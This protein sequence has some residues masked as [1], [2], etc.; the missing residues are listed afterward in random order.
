VPAKSEIH[1]HRRDVATDTWVDTGVLVD[2]RGKSRQDVLV[3]GPTVYMVSRFGFTGSPPQNRLLRFTYQP[4]AQTY[5]PDAG[6]PVDIAGGGAEALTVAKD[7]RGKLWIAYALNGQVQVAHTL[8]SDA[9]WTAPFQPPVTEGTIATIDDDAGVIAL[10]GGKIGVFWSNQAT[11]KFY[12]GIH[13]DGAPDLDRTAWKLETAAAGSLIADDHFNL[14]LA[15]DGR[16]FVAVKTSIDAAGQVTIGLLVR[17][18]AGVWSRLYAVA[19]FD[20]RPSRPICVLD[21]VNRRVYVLYSSALSDIY[22]KVSDMNAIAFPTTDRG[23]PFMLSGT[24]PNQGLNDPTSAKLGPDPTSG[25][26]ILA[27]TSETNRY[28][29]NWISRPTP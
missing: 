7:S 15:A 6:F 9:E 13:T 27:S 8:G 10:P 19:N 4:A 5:T 18:A 17:S 1:I 2:D 16:L 24:S 21:E 23:T 29:H 14:K 28:W 3:D 11:Q 22:Y 25:I 12:F 20:E 26:L